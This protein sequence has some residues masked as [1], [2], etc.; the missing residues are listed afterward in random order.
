[1]TMSGST[2]KRPDMAVIATAQA[3]KAVVE[4]YKQLRAE[5]VAPGAPVAYRITVRQLEALIRLSEALARAACR[6]TILLA[7][8]KEVMHLHHMK[9]LAKHCCQ[10]NLLQQA[11]GGP[12]VMVITYAGQNAVFL[13]S[14]VCTRLIRWILLEV[15][16]L[17]VRTSTVPEAKRGGMRR[18]SDW[19]RTASCQSRRPRRRWMKMI[20]WRMLQKFL[21]LYSV[22][23]A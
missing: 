20:G 19:S 14:G 4:A 7:D 18:L 5:D 1:M 17:K 22:F 15:L 6:E 8:V 10:P 9:T 2:H 16:R 3:A 11:C 23:E 12:T 21:L 13:W